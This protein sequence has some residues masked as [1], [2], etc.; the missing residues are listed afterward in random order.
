MGNSAINKQNNKICKVL[1]FN[2]KRF[3]NQESDRY[4]DTAFTAYVSGMQKTLR[5]CVHP[6][7]DNLVITLAMYYNNEALIS[8]ISKV[9]K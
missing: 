1:D 4:M 8:Q 2:T 6:L 9:T 3:L 7:G 5:F